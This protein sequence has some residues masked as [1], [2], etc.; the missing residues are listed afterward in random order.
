MLAIALQQ[1]YMLMAM[2][3]FVPLAGGLLGLVTLR[4]RQ[5]PGAKAFC[6]VL[7]C[8][9]IVGSIQGAPYWHA[10]YQFEREE[11]AYFDR[12]CRERA[13]VQLPDQPTAAQGLVWIDPGMA[14]QSFMTAGDAFA[15]WVD[16]GKGRYLAAEV[17]DGTGQAFTSIRWDA[18][19][20]RPGS[21]DTV[22]SH[23]AHPTLPFTIRTTRVTTR[24]DERHGVEGVD[25]TITETDSGRVVARRVIFGQYW[26]DVARWELPKQTCPDGALK[27]SDCDLNGCS[28]ANFVL[29]AVPPVRA[30]EAAAAYDLYRGSGQHIVSCAF[31]VH[32]GPSLGPDDIESWVEN[33]PPF[34]RSTYVRIKGTSDQV[35]CG[36]GSPSPTTVPRLWFVDSAAREGKGKAK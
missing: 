27:K 15:H 30:S 2:Y 1:F 18:T 20:S 16:P 33:E 21:P 36:I 35:V 12:A 6:V 25:T 31:G 24:E 28:S 13:L 7:L 3:F 22:Q 5:A 19:R 4:G 26:P 8:M 10:R 29:A 17:P 23:V 32:V 14:R 9:G 11:Q 34:G